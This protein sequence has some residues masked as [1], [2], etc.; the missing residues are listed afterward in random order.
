ME[1]VSRESICL[2][3][4]SK[5]PFFFDLEF[6]KVEKKVKPDLFKKPST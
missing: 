1:K 3:F 6:L 5:A 2:S 4:A